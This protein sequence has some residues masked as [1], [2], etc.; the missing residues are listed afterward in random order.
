[1][2]AFEKDLLRNNKFFVETPCLNEEVEQIIA[3]EETNRQALLVYSNAPVGKNFAFKNALQKKEGN[4][5]FINFNDRSNMSHFPG[6]YIVKEIY[7]QLDKLG[8]P[9]N[10]TFPLVPE[11]DVHLDLESHI[12]N[13]LGVL[14]KDLYSL[15]LDEPLY[16]LIGNIDMPFDNDF[17]MTFYRH[18]IFD[19]RELPKNLHA[20]LITSD[21]NQVEE[22]KEYLEVVTLKGNQD[23]PK[24]FFKE[25]LNKYSRT[26]DDE[27][28]LLANPTLRICDYLYIA[29]YAIN[30]AGLKEYNL[31][32][33]T[34][35]MKNNTDEILLF[36]CED[37]L[38]RL[39][40]FGKVIF[41]ETLLDLYMFNYGLVIEDAMNPGRY[42]LGKDSNLLDGYN[43]ISKEERD[44]IYT[45]LQFFTVEEA[46]RLIISD[47][48]IREFI[49]R[50]AMYFT[51]IVTSCYQE[52][53]SKA[54]DY[55]FSVR[56]YIERKDYHE[57]RFA[58]E[59]DLKVEGRYEK[60]H[61]VRYA[62]FAPLCTRI[63]KFISSYGVMLEDCPNQS[64]SKI[65]PLGLFMLAYIER[66]AIIYESAYD[67]SD[68]QDLLT[69]KHLMFFITSKSR[70][71]MR[72]ILNRY[73]NTCLEYQRKF[74]GGKGDRGSL[75]THFQGVFLYLHKEE[76]YPDFKEE[77]LL[78]IAEVLN[79]NG[80][81]RNPP[82]KDVFDRYMTAPITDFALVN[83]GEELVK[84]LNYLLEQLREEEPNFEFLTADLRNFCLQ[85]QNDENVYH[86]IMYA[87]LAFRTYTFLG[88]N[89]RV[90]PTISSWLEPIMEDIRIYVEYC[91]YPE[92]YGLI[93]MY[94]GRIY[95]KDYLDKM[96]Q[97][98]HLLHSQGFFLEPLPFVNAFKYF[99]SLEKKEDK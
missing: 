45:Y 33:K 10:G 90:N 85:Y 35:L 44:L 48:I 46:G 49:G 64:R 20:F 6:Y 31:A 18:F 82:F 2:Q 9:H 28:L 58:Y 81:L 25:L 69:N 68:F 98:I 50:N 92:V 77:L 66:A 71:L 89:H 3:L 16:I 47:R 40:K 13:M 62:L 99:S 59:Y 65:D 55:V 74:Q 76:E 8:I 34:L 88:E 39:S 32:I 15:E 72:R 36:V 14:N 23:N 37:F 73:V 79:E 17:S 61:T 42:L 57:Q 96:E 5:I 24:L 86:K 26:V 97:G 94:F 56:E 27:L 78:L 22:L 95:V 29:G 70:R 80:A 43:E 87:Y 4:K 30:Y 54:L 11:S 7:N 75:D 41:A 51:N 93:Y 63:N 84:Y 52:R 12:D 19:K 83:G 91:Y 21:A 67:Y 1:M 53:L 60:K 38:S